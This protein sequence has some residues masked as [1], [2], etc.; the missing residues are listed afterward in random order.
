MPEL[1]KDPILD[2]WVIISS[3][4]GKRPKDFPS[5]AVKSRNGTC[6]FCKGNEKMTPPEVLAY[7]S[8]SSGPDTPGWT[9]RVVPNKFPALCSEGEIGRVGEGMFDKMN[10]IGAHEVIIETPE[11]EIDLENLASGRFEDFLNAFRERIVSLKKDPR[12]RYIL[13]FKNHG[14][15]SGATLEHSHTQLIALPI[16]PELVSDEIASAR[17]HYEYKERCI[18]CDIIAQEK[19]HG[20]RIVAENDRFLTLCPYAPRFPFE[21]WVLPQFHAARYESIGKDDLP[22]LGSLLRESLMRMRTALGAP[23]YNFV[24]HTAPVQGN[25]DHHYHWHI[26]IMPKLTKMAGFEQGTGFYINP[27]SPEE[28]TR[29]LRNT[30]I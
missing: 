23:P 8:N 15:A 10:G 4:R 24:L 27:V 26:E 19:G 3:E 28:A 6:P 29:V 1:R 16:I 18:F 20:K 12:F 13:V 7:R 21:M 9:L 2:R 11:H 17:R 25:C 14:E 5:P 22:K 30:K